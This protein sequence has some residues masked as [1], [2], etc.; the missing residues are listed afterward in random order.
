MAWME[1]SRIGAWKLGAASIHPESAPQ[2]LWWLLAARPQHDVHASL[3]TP[4]EWVALG[5]MLLLMIFVLAWSMTRVLAR[6]FLQMAASVTAFARDEQ[7]TPLPVD[8]RDE[9]GALARAFAEMRERV[10]ERADRRA[11]QR[12]LLLLKSADIGIFFFNQQGEMGFINPAGER[13]LGFASG[14]LEDQPIHARIHHHYADGRPYPESECP[15]LQSMREGQPRQVTDEV[16]WRKDGTPMPVAYSCAPVVEDGRLVGALVTFSDI[17]EKRQSEQELLRSRANADQTAIEEQV[18]EALLRWSLQDSSL[19][20]YLRQALKQL[21][22]SVS[23]LNLLP[24]GGVFLNTLV[25]GEPILQLVVS[26]ELGPDVERLC[27]QVAHGHCLCGRAALTRRLQ[28][29]SEVNELHH[30]CFPGMRPHGHYNVPLLQ[31]DDVL[32]VLALYLPEGHAFAERE[33]AFL[34][35]VAEVLSMGILRRLNASAL[36]QA[37]ADAEEGN[38]AKSRFLAAMSHE[39]RTPMNGVIGMTGLLLDTDLDA[40]QRRMT[41]IIRESGE[42]LLTIINDILDFSKLEADR[43]ELDL[44]E[45][46]LARL[47]ESVVD[48]LAPRVCQAGIEINYFV[49]PTVQGYFLGDGGRIRQV[50]MNLLGNAIKFTEQGAISVEAL[51]KPLGDERFEVQVRVRDTGIGIAPEAQGRLF[52]SFS[53]ADQTVTRRFG[54]TGL[55]LAISRRLVELMDGSIQ[56]D[57]ILGQGSTFSF[58]LPLP[59]VKVDRQIDPAHFRALFKDRLVLIVDDN[60]INR[61]VLERIL[62]NWQVPHQSAASGPEALALI[63]GLREGGLSIHALLLDYQ[64]PAMDGLA[65]VRQLREQHPQTPIPVIL[66][67]SINRSEIESQ[68][69][70]EE[71]HA[72]LQKPVRH[73]LL[74]NTLVSALGVN[75]VIHQPEDPTPAA[76][77]PVAQG[78]ELHILVAEDNP[79][80]QRVALGMLKALGHQA[81]IAENGSHAVAKVRHGQFDLILMDVQMPEMDGLEATRAI[82]MLDT[83][84]A[85]VPIIAMTADA[86]VE[87]REKCLEAGMNDYLSKPVNRDQLASMLLRFQNMPSTNPALMAMINPLALQ[88]LADEVDED[89]VH[90]LLSM[91]VRDTQG[92][93]DKLD[94]ALAEG[95]YARMEQAAHALKG[96]AGSIGLTTL[97]TQ[98]AQLHAHCQSRQYAYLAQDLQALRQCLALSSQA[99]AEM[100]PN[101]RL[102]PDA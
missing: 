94:H 20:I 51:A 93:L 14:E 42:A 75:D 56:V 69:A 61:E 72:F 24:K 16:F 26:Q 40:E 53:Q 49:D 30:T 50:L 64:M 96:S 19:E 10:R 7:D 65:V 98:A 15:M 44:H 1:Y 11:E 58:K 43:L 66:L 47:V 71:L 97:D 80:N 67:S 70:L 82:R 83:P 33:A 73:S 100:F 35:R 52:Q 88:Q 41:E 102:T 27:A 85:K 31:H 5:L 60:A 4:R 9:V 99:L 21:L 17:T 34:N 89:S 25:N 78:T 36:E 23:W 86:T 101:W 12:A 28:Y 29:V 95:A 37:R 59:R 54:G 91:F 2:R 77:S 79:V 22:S 92:L 74:Y 68:A 62:D 3:A 45:F 6:P 8:S 81:D 38:R 84:S 87:D 48:I 39:I 55:G 76:K 32:G 18:L 63:R 57:S 13:L 46:S 90:E